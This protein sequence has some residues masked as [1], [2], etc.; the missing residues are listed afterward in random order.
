MNST[1][2]KVIRIHKL[3]FINYKPITEF[4]FRLNNKKRAA[5]EPALFYC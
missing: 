2:N 1:S 3:E 4:N 5:F